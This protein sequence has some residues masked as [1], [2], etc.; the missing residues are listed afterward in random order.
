M[1]QAI[2]DRSGTDALELESIKDAQEALGGPSRSTIYRLA[3]EGHLTFVKVGA[4]TAVIKA[5]RRA[6]VARLIAAGNS[7]P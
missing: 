1:E 6:Y 4:R 5:S 7:A 3:R 2:D